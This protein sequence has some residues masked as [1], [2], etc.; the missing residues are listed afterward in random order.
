MI[1]AK[2]LDEIEK[3]LGSAFSKARKADPRVLFDPDEN[4]YTVEK[5]KGGWYTVQAGTTP[6]GEM[7]FACPCYGALHN[8][9]CYHV[10]AIVLNFLPHHQ[11]PKFDFTYIRN[12]KVSDLTKPYLGKDQ[13]P[14]ETV[15]K[16][17]I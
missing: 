7:F 14:S 13:K 12:V 9:A 4:Q 6:D 10:A 17:R 15:G 11:P 8:K 1:K 16:L 3:I 2:T 5:S